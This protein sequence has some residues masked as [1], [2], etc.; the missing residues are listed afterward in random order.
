M[1]TRGPVSDLA[2]TLPAGAAGTWYL[3]PLRE[4]ITPLEFSALGDVY[5][6]GFTAAGRAYGVPTDPAR[7]LRIN[8]YVFGQGGTIA[9]RG[10]GRQ[11]L[12]DGPLGGVVARLHAVWRSEF[13]PEIREHLVAWSE[14]DLAEQPL[15]ALIENLAETLRRA[16]RLSELHF[17]ILWPAKLAMSEFDEMYQEL[18]HPADSLESYRLLQG[19]ENE[20]V[21]MG[22]RLWTLGRLAREDGRLLET[23]ARGDVAAALSRRDGSAD[24][25]TFAADLE[26]FLDTYGIHTDG[27]GL[28]SPSWREDPTALL[29][30][31]RK[32]ADLD[33][34]GDPA[35]SLARLASDRERLVDRARAHVRASKPEL[36][37][38]FETLLSAAQAGAVIKEDHHFYIDA[39]MGY[40]L[41]RSGLQ[42]GRALVAAGRLDHAEDVLLL[43]REELEA[44]AAPGPLQAVVAERKSEMQAF[45]GIEPPEW[46]GDPPTGQRQQEGIFERG[47]RKMHGSPSP[48]TASDALLRGSPASPG[49]VTGKARCLRSLDDASC[50]SAG[51]IIVAPAASPMWTTLFPIAGGLVT[52]SGGALSHCAVIAREYGLPAVVGCHDILRKVRDGALIRIDG[53]RGTITVLNAR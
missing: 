14:A 44:S 33:D 16:A 11:A 9:L 32:F 43:T 35:A 6:A 39:R 22:R 4:Q 37:E 34:G 30:Q 29:R 49:I 42:L 50:L 47:M 21:R 40:E 13:L 18:F 17:R 15:E 8:T 27:F 38:Q 12:L 2:W 53:S 10:E 1:S 23:L 48:V 3:D 28:R 20:T 45:R 26:A 5:V 36:S 19:F 41:R 51:D 31:L 25:G 7:L 24:G 46:L 52:E